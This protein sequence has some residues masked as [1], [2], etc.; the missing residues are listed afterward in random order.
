[1]IREE[2]FNSI[3]LDGMQGVKGRKW[4]LAGPGVIPMGLADPDFPTAMEIKKA[5]YDAVQDEDVYYADDMKT[6]TVMAEKLKRRNS[7]DA[8]PDDVMTTQGVI[9]GMW[10]AIRYACKPG[11]EVVV[12]DPMYYPF[13][14]AAETG[15]AKLVWH[16]LSQDEGYRFNP[17]DLNEA[18]TPKTKLLFVCNPH[19]PC[20]RVLTKE[21]LRGIAEVAVDRKLIVMADELWEDVT[22]DERKHISLASIGPEIAERTITSFGFS[23]TY[24]VAGLQM[25]YLVATNKEMMNKLKKL[26]SRVFRNPGTSSLSLAAAPVMLSD[27]LKW[28]RDGLVKHTEK[29]RDI[30]YKR[31]REIGDISCPKL[32]GTYLMFPDFST[33]GMNS[34]EL[35]DYLLKE[36]K[37]EVSHG[38]EFGPSGEG[39]IRMCIATSEEILNEALDRIEKALKKLR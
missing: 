16:R 6:R 33:Y 15:E 3:T 7:I 26:C 32:E 38:T 19:N 31:L 12:T 11:E 20:G 23:K 35:R 18:I 4:G 22:L 1:M 29:V 21:E 2:I 14:E 34:V 17:D 39:H 10:L 25:G 8:S 37:V 13:F 9:P 5:L 24:G 30:T 28:W 36:A 27:S